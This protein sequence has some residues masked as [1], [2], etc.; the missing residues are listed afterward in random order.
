MLK[1]PLR[2]LFF[3]TSMYPFIKHTILVFCI[4]RWEE[5]VP[6]R[7][8]MHAADERLLDR[9]GSCSE[10]ACEARHQ[11]LDIAL[12]QRGQSGAFKALLSI[13]DPLVQVLGDHCDPVP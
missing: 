12:W 11:Q 8:E 4:S 1:I 9:M 10:D 3:N 5:T 13:L 6:A 2:S 7:E